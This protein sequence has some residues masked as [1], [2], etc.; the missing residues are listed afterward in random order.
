MNADMTF[1]FDLRLSAFICG[2]RSGG[3]MKA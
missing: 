2:Y 3:F 1:I